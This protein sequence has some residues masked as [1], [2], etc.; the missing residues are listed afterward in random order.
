MR[1]AS[2][3]VSQVVLDLNGTLADTQGMV[4]RTRHRL[5]HRLSELLEAPEEELVLEF[6]AFLDGNSFNPD[7]VESLPSTRRLLE[8]GRP[9]SSRERALAAALRTASAE[10]RRAADAELAPYPGVRESLERLRSRGVA[11]HV[12]SGGRSPFV[13]G[14][15]RVLGLDGLVDAVY[16]PAAKP[17]V[18]SSLDGVSLWQTRI[19]ELPHDAK[20]PSRELLVRI[21]EDNA[22]AAAATLLVG[23]NPRTDGL[24]ALGT[25][26]RFVLARWGTDAETRALLD[27][28]TKVGGVREAEADPGRVAPEV[29]AC[30]ERSLDE[31][32]EHFDF[33]PAPGRGRRLTA[34]R[35]R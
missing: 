26:V 5:L 1:S 8:P 30:L 6:R 12:W 19:V 34:G 17:G 24:S 13:R 35:A 14:F 4:A 10:L 18:V 2:G 7:I 22:S 25:G 32:F 23:N 21:L 29:A 28:L 27:H 15:L 20:K 11:A 9:L 31:L 16:C 3:P 33:V